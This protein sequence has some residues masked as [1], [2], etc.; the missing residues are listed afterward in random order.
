ME[1]IEKTLMNS[2]DKCVSVIIPSYNRG[3][4]L[5]RTVP[6]YIQ[7]NVGEVIIV[8]DAS[9]DNTPKVVE[10]L[11]EKYPEIIYVRMPVN[12]KQTAAKNIGIKKATLPYIY[13]G[14][15]DSFITINTIE[16]LLSTLNKMNADVVGARALYMDNE[17]DNINITNFIRRKSKKFTTLDEVKKFLDIHNLFSISFDWDYKEPIQ[18][19]FCHACAL[20]KKD[21]LNDITFDINYTGNAYREE[22]DL[23][24]RITSVGYK[25]YYDPSAI[26]INLPRKTIIKNSSILKYKLKSAYFEFLNTY[27][28]LKKNIRFLQS[29]YSID[30]GYKY[31]WCVYF[32]D[33]MK[34]KIY[35]F[36]KLINN[37][38]LYI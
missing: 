4:L 20:V 11:K 26:Q 28:Y 34:I 6:S 15:D 32:I 24:T 18:V 38:L 13:F 35:K 23:F 22:T 2:T 5:E 30:E 7:E 25:I 16:I 33:A 12:S 19:P 29:Y 8:D 31:L 27:K 14:D 10:K 37:T 21:I 9:T 3:H 17:N 1:R 36:F